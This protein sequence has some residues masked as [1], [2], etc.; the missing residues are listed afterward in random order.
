M[1][2]AIQ[3]TAIKPGTGGE[4]ICTEPDGRETS[5]DPT[6]TTVKIVSPTAD[7]PVASTTVSQCTP[8][9]KTHADCTTREGTRVSVTTNDHGDILYL[10]Q[11]NPD[12]QW[13]RLC[14]KPGFAATTTA[15]FRPGKPGT[16]D[17]PSVCRAPIDAK[18]GPGEQALIKKTLEQ[19]A[20][21]ARTD[22]KSTLDILKI[23]GG[24]DHG[25]FSIEKTKDGFVVSQKGGKDPTPL[26]ALTPCKE[27]VT[28]KI[29]PGREFT[30]TGP[31][32]KS[33]LKTVEGMIRNGGKM[34]SPPTPRRCVPIFPLL[35]C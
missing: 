3:C 26:M 22:L 23:A 13:E 28:V 35:G 11:Q 21:Q 4:A 18:F 33:L 14:T 10:D 29:M 25:S 9:D 5:F 17:H 32:S 20:A 2:H 30:L 27:G 8:T 24:K 19:K 16:K 7:K 31:T 15:L 6:A 12:K 34:A 1:P